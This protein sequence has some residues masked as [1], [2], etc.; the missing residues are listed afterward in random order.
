MSKKSLLTVADEFE[1]NLS[2]MGFEECYN[3]VELAETFKGVMSDYKKM[4]KTCEKEG[5]DVG[6]FELD[7]YE[8][9]F[10]SGEVD[11]REEMI[12]R[13]KERII[14]LIDVCESVPQ[15]ISQKYTKDLFD[16]INE[17]D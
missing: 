14:S 12:E 6:E 13:I 5:L 9:E 4:I 10:V 8:E 17:D 7:K 11:E 1:K 2:E 3:E 16:M 15:K